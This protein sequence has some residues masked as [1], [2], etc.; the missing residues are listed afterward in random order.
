MMEYEIFDFFGGAGRVARAARESGMCAVAFDICYHNDPKVFDI[1][2]PAG[3]SFPSC[4][5]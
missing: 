4:T 5:C 1:N 2:T 3:F